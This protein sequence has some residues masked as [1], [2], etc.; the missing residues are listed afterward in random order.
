EF[1]THK[2]HFARN[3]ALTTDMPFLYRLLCSKLLGP[4]IPDPNDP[5][6]LAD[7]DVDD[8][9]GL[10]IDQPGLHP[11]DPSVHNVSGGTVITEEDV[12]AVDGTHLEVNADPA[13]RR[14]ARAE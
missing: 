9:T 2:Q 14:K 8:P 7:V 6:D 12:S 5:V 11:I 4:N 1:F 13:A 10:G 3:N